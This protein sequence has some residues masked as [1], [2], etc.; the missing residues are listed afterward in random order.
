N[1]R[2]HPR[3]K[4]TQVVTGRLAAEAP[5]IQQ[6][7]R[8]P[9][10]RSV[11]GGVDGLTWVKADLSQI[12]L[13]LAAWLAQEETMLTAYRGGADLHALTA[14]RVFGV[15]PSTEWKPG[16]SARDAGKMLNF[17][18]LYGA[19]PKK[20]QLIAYRQYGIQITEKEAEAYRSLFF[21]SYPRLAA[22]HFE[23][24]MEVRSAGQI[25][26]PLGRV[27]VFPEVSSDDEW[28]IKR[29]EREA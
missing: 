16:K 22:W 14:E 26:S 3:Y 9:K 21:D 10:Y 7:P 27:R 23:V 15:D 17:S 28:E 29:A 5:N 19:Y 24:K 18:L 11:F 25:V 4:P 1:N 12:E 13:R 20:L 8:D 6:V 2:L